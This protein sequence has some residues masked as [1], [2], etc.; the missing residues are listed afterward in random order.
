MIH[1][2]HILDTTQSKKTKKRGDLREYAGL[3]NG[4]KSLQAHHS[5]SPGPL[6]YSLGKR[7]VVEEIPYTS[8]LLLLDI[9]FCF[10]GYLSFKKA[11]ESAQRFL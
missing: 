8:P 4:F 9:D 10:D 5:H 1:F 2:S 11:N 6:F 7:C 3:K